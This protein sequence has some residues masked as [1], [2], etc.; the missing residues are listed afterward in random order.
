MKKQI[1]I[2]PI[3]LTVLSPTYAQEQDY[4]KHQRQ[5]F[6]MAKSFNDPLVARNSLYNI[7]VAEKNAL[8]LDTLA[9]YY[10]Q[11]QSYTSSLLVAQEALKY[12]KDN[13]LMRELLA[14]CYEELGVKDKALTEYETLYLKN[15]SFSTL[16]KIAF[17]QYQLKR[18]G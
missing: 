9:L 7:I 2:I 11:Y 8:L 16:Y 17:L 14:I 12:N 4:V 18:Y 13:H 10:Y 6:E 5:I 15:K 1:F 3:I